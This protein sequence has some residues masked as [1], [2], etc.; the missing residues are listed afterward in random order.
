MRRTYI[1]PEFKN[2]KVYGTY[3]MFEESNFFC[4]KMLEI[5]DFVYIENQDLI[6][7]QKSTGEQLDI[8]IESSLQSYVYSSP[9]SKKDN[10]KLKLDE[11]QPAYQKNNNTRWIL[12]VN[13]KE[14]FYNYI[15]S[16]LKKYRTFEGLRN[17]MTTENDVNVAIKKYITN[18]IL[19]RYKFN[20]IDLLVES[21]S[22]RD[23][24]I[25]RYKNNWKPSLTSSNLL[26][27]I[28]TETAFDDS[29]IKVTF[30]QERSSEDYCINYFFNLLYEKI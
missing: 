29:I 21:Q 15:Y 1:S 9:T 28:Q 6:Y 10:H 5:E 16:I 12:E 27:K 8:I 23:Q 30:N 19:P 7:Y 25:L 18:N 13:L 11:T 24:D 3:N 2:N 4:G 20:K 22:L 26:S 14:I 17:E